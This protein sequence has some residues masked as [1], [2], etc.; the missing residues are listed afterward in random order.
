[1]I[2]RSYRWS[3]KRK[4]EEAMKLIASALDHYRGE[5]SEASAPFRDQIVAKET[6]TQR[7]VMVFTVKARWLDVIEVGKH[8]MTR[9]V[10]LRVRCR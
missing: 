9:S 8:S 6:S 4:P 7:N 5:E 3:F 1:M 2:A 10:H